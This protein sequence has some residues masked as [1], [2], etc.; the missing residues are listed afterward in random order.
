MSSFFKKK[1]DD[2]NVFKSIFLAYFIL[3]FHVA[4]L[5][6]LGMLVLFFGGIVHYM[7][8]IL[9]GGGVLLAGSGYFLLRYMKKQS[10]SLSKLLM[11]PEF[12]DKNLEVNVLG[13]LASVKISSENGRTQDSPAMLEY[14]DDAIDTQRL[15]APEAP[16]AV[17]VKELTE[18]AR[19][20][21]KNLITLD[22]YDRA[23][24]DL[25][26]TKRG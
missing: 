21:D 3:L 22:E 19:L 8:W 12:R 2:S 9:V 24:Q 6:V 23:K 4:L 20:L 1:F 14:G 7:I 26:N 11:L 15:E 5:A 18:L 13:G 17:R 10:E 16:E 25:F